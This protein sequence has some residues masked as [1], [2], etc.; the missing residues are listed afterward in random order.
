V[1]VDPASKL[2]FIIGGNLSLCCGWFRNQPSP[3][4]ATVHSIVLR[5]A[6]LLV[7]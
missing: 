4:T 2:V 7:V 1:S 5:T 3:M 6:H